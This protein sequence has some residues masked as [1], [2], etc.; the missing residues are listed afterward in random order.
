MSEAESVLIYQALLI[1]RTE[2]TLLSLF[3]QGKLNGTVHTCIGQEWV[4]VALSVAL[5]EGD[6]VFSNHRGHGHFIACTGD[7]EGLIAEIMGKTT[8]VCNGVGGSQHLHSKNYFSSGI[9]GGMIPIAV[10]KSLANKI[11]GRK[12]ISVVLIGD[13]TLGE[14]NVYESLNIA[15]KWALP[16]LILVENNGYSQST[17]SWQ[18][19]AGTIR[20]RAEAFG[21]A[22]RKSD[23]W[24][25]KKLVEGTK[26]AIHFVRENQKPLLYEIE[27]YRLKSHS[28]GDDNRDRN[29]IAKYEER[30]YLTQFLK[31]DA[32][33]VSEF[34]S[35]IDEKIRGAVESAEMAEI[36]GFVAKPV[37][38]GKEVHWSDMHFS[39]ERYADLIYKAFKRF[40]KQYSKMIM[41]GED[42]EGPYGGGVQGLQRSFSVVSGESKKHPF[43]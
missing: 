30:D 41:I 10:G 42:I 8:G 33:E 18:T 4:G 40:F 39:S 19:L 13:G 15:S 7:I 28:K 1:R 16:L 32:K 3:S 37:E 38:H 14:G 5:S 43:E 35:T 27:T 21:I 6:T 36:G 12:D 11:D 9:Q 2:E 24:D 31:S 17:A 20:G 23:T 34:L 29:E 25:W 22:Y 26:E